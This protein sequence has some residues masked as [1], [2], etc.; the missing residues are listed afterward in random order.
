MVLEED[1]GVLGEGVELSAERRKGLA[2]DRVGVGRG[3]DVRT[4][5]VNGRVDHEGRSIDRALTVDHLAVVIHQDQIR[6]PNVSK[7]HAERVD[8]EVVEQF[9]VARRDMPGDALGESELAKDAQGSGETLL[10]MTSLGFNRGEGGRNV[11]DQ[12][13]LAFRESIH[14]VSHALP[15]IS[16]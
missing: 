1:A 16:P 15:P 10:A 2:V 4:R 13:G 6:D 7:V 14:Y 11:E 3:D 12:L 5:G 8:P 9:G